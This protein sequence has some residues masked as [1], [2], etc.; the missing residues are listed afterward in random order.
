MNEEARK[1]LLAIARQALVA[2]TQ[3]Q[4]IPSP[5]TN[6]EYPSDCGAFVTLHDHEERLRGC[7]GCMSATQ[8]LVEVVTEM[9][10]SA[11]LRDPRFSPVGADEVEN[12]SIEIS[13]LSAQV[14]VSSLE[15]IQIGRDGLV[16]VAP[17]TRGVLLPQVASERDWDAKTFVEQTCVK[18]NLP[19][20]AYLQEHVQV[21]RFSAEVFS[22]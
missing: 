19:P 1:E 9:A 7:I 13:V 2:C 14:L 4:A 6:N 18:A 10:R 3:N 8:P 17:S 11:A 21:F 12:L 5:E 15:D 20:N 22:E 16:I